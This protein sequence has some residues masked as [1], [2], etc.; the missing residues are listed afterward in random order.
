[1][2]SSLLENVLNRGLPRSPRARQLCAELTGR[3]VAVDVKGVTR[4]VIASVGDSLS[5]VRDTAHGAAAPVV[6]A[7]SANS[8]GAADTA[9]SPDAT[10]IGAPLALLELAGS[11][12]EAAIQRGDVVISGDLDV[13]QKF[14]EL[15]LLLRPDIEEELALFIGDTP[16]HQLGRFARSALGWGKNAADTTARN[17]SEFL[18]HE[19]GDLVSRPEGNQFLKG[20]DAVRE[21]AD[22][23]EA[24]FELLRALAAKRRGS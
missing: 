19:R 24:R 9:G 15:F 10:I 3:K 6:V 20:V 16:A 2:L 13:S 12:P 11:E 18:A 5:V 14:R 21:D 8:A 1:M 23:L 4:V 17:I 22:R 7:P